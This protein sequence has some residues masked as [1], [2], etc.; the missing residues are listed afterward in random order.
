MPASAG[1][2]FIINSE[3]IDTPLLN[4][5][6]HHNDIIVLQNTSIYLSSRQLLSAFNWAIK[7]AQFKYL[8]KC[9]DASYVSMRGIVGE[10]KRN[11]LPAGMAI[12][13]YFVGNENVTRTGL[14]SERVWNQCVTYLPYAE[15]GG[16]VVSRDLVA[17]V[18]DLG[19]LLYHMDNEDI[20]LGTWVAPFKTVQRYHDKRF[21]TGTQS[22]GCMNNYLISHPVTTATM[23]T[24]HQRMNE[25]NGQICDEEYEI[26]SSYN[27]NW[28]APVTS[29]CND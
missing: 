29:C 23:Q 10:L 18:T 12:W 8:L 14:K 16:Y 7:N 11:I 22:R 5:I 2:R 13:G 1:Y 24:I 4:E 21:N 28:S 19:P 27:Y 3:T 6:Y 20:G 15:G 17:M 25:N 26:I 9:N